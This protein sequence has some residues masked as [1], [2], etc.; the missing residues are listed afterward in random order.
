M[1]GEF[2]LIARYL[3]PLAE[4]E[5]GALGLRDDAAVISPPVGRDLVL[6]A[7]ALVEGVHFLPTDPPGLVARKLLRVNLS[8]LAAMGARPRGYLMTTAWPKGRAEAWIADFA[9]GLARDQETFGIGLL[10]GDTTGTPG[11]LSLSLTAIGTTPSGSRLERGGARAGDSLYVSGTLGDGA[12]GLRV[13]K[14]ALDGLDAAERDWLIDRY[15]LPRPRLALGA[16][17]LEQGLASAAIDVSDGL[18]ADVGHLAAASGLAARIEA[19]AVPLSA[20]ARSALARDPGLLARVLTGGDD[21]EL[22]FTA[23]P[24]RAERLAALA[25]QLDL[26]LARVGEMTEGGGVA[27]MDAEGRSMELETA[28]W[29]HF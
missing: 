22:A 5:P 6:A 1:L 13:L 19:A 23:A 4:G 21:Y 28:G 9:A 10:G 7:D 2:E 24:D 16:A 14:G 27:V 18:V 20:A 12:L 3:A 11:P 17:L 29:T 26:P 25:G 15:R 8:D